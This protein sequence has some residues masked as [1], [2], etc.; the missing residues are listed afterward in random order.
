MNNFVDIATFKRVINENVELLE[1]LEKQ[2]HD[3]NTWKS[4]CGIIAE[5][6][7]KM[8]EEVNY[9]TNDW[10]QFY[11]LESQNYKKY[12][13]VMNHCVFCSLLKVDTF[14]WLF[15]KQMKTLRCPYC[16]LP[17]KLNCEKL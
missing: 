7:V 12:S 15:D 1:E 4:L 5:L 8:R 16:L 6:I 17:E 11:H 13:D 9:S 3:I 14:C 2:C 10:K